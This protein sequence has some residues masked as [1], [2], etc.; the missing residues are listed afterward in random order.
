MPPAKSKKEGKVKAKA[1]AAAS[2]LPSGGVT[3]SDVNKKILTEFFDAA[4]VVKDSPVFKDITSS[5][6][7]GLTDKGRSAIQAPFDAKVYAS[8]M[9]L[10]QNYKCGGNFFWIGLESLSSP[11][12]PINP[13]SINTIKKKY[14]SK[15]G[16]YPDT[17]VI[18]I[19]DLSFD[20]LA[21][22]AALQCVSPDEMKV[23]F[24]SALAERINDGADAEELNQWKH[25]ALTVS[26]HFK[27][28]ASQDEVFFAALNMRQEVVTKFETLARTAYQWIFEIVAFRQRKIKEMGGKDGNDKEK[29]MSAKVVQDLFNK[30]SES[31][32]G[33]TSAQSTEQVNEEFVRAAIAVYDK[34]LRNPQAAET[35]LWFEHTFG[36]ASPLDSV[37]KL[38]RIA[39]RIKSENVPWV[40]AQMKDKLE[41][42]LMGPKDFPDRVL[43]GSADGGGRGLVDL[44]VLKNEMRV[45]LIGSEGQRLGITT[46]SLSEMQRLFANFETYRGK[47]QP[48]TGDTSSLDRSYQT[49]WSKSS[50]RFMGFVEEVVFG[51]AYD[52]YLKTGCRAGKSPADILEYPTLQTQMNSIQAMIKQE[53]EAAQKEQ[54]DSLLTPPASTSG[55][56]ASSGPGGGA[57]SS[58]GDEQP[59][60]GQSE[61]DREI[62]RLVHAQITITVEPESQTELIRALQSSSVGKMLGTA[63]QNYI[64]IVFD[65]KF[66]GE[67]DTKPHIRIPPWP[68]TRAKKLVQAVLEGRSKTAGY[69]N[70]QLV[71]GDFFLICDGGKH[72]N[73]HKIKNLFK[74]ENGSNYKHHAACVKVIK[75]EQGITDRY[76]GTRRGWGSISQDEYFYA[77]ALEKMKLPVVRRKHFAGTNKGNTITDVPVLAATACW[78]VPRSKKFEI[79]D[80]YIIRVG[81]KE[82]DDDS[83]SSEEAVEDTLEL[84][85]SGSLDI[86][87]HYPL[88]S[89][90]ALMM[91]ES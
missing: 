82:D 89:L 90:L 47:V 71:P 64:A 75:S 77:I 13:S 54:Q 81:G 37:F 38:H 44:Y 42:K 55:G 73:S 62:T 53:K 56:A 19:P 41:S 39:K 83:S 28:M 36:M 48:L 31:G 84:S 22:R 25:M 72:G 79:I 20:P 2:G 88:V 40:F 11:G 70:T 33:Y 67:S 16:V 18:A 21:H 87:P 52:G 60:T 3:E 34:I 58:I 10:E 32:E 4:K 86:L 76:A 9:K 12:V 61:S 59:P 74:D 23:A 5:A 68:T 30:H 57:T 14:F 27:V 26:M 85:P 15:P 29:S 50:L 8:T 63:H 80:K 45:F 35:V 7:I 69:E 66:C 24:V 65:V 49:G 78:T 6:P 46:S 51:E 17:L 43:T 91:F 1:A